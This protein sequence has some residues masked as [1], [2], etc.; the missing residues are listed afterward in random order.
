MYISYIFFILK[1]KHKQHKVD[2]DDHGKY[3]SALLLYYYFTLSE[4]NVWN[5]IIFSKKKKTFHFIPN[6]RGSR[7]KY[8]CTYCIFILMLFLICRTF[9]YN[10]YENVRVMYY[11]LKC[12]ILVWLLSVHRECIIAVNVYTQKREREEKKENLTISFYV[13]HIYIPPCNF[14]SLHFCLLRHLLGTQA[15]KW[16]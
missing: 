11:S 6:F 2:N 9:T 16:N 3:V 4:K 12:F 7:W 1:N 8:S 14:N 10:V 15:K 13:A 5:K